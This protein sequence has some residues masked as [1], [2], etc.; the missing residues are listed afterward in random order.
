MIHAL[1]G[2]NTKVVIPF[3]IRTFPVE[4]MHHVL[5]EQK[6]RQETMHGR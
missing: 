4:N 6:L 5:V 3:Y 2:H 1:A